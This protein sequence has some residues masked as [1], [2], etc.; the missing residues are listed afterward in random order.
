MRLLTCWSSTFVSSPRF[1]WQ[2]NS[3]KSSY[4]CKKVHYHKLLFYPWQLKLPLIFKGIPETGRLQALQSIMLLMPDENREALQYLLLFL[5]EVAEQS[6]INQVRPS[7]YHNNNAIL[8]LLKYLTLYTYSMH[9]L[10][11]K[12]ST[13]LIG[14]LKMFSGKINM[15]NYS[16]YKDNVFQF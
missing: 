6:D 11:E 12:W 14:T 13:I 9:I 1:C 7:S 10:P 2:T 4:L 15:S 8:I 16:H 3:Q 5:S